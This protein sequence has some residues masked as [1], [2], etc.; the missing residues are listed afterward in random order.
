MTL[1]RFPESLII[2]LFPLLFFAANYYH[3]LHAYPIEDAFI[4]Y[5]YVKNFLSEGV[6]NFFPGGQPTEGATDF[7]WF[8]GLSAISAFGVSPWVSAMVL[9]ATGL[10]SIAVI[11]GK[12]TN[13]NRQHKS[14]M[15]SLFMAA[16]LFQTHLHAN[17]GGFNVFFYASFIVLIYYLLLEKR[18]LSWVPLLSLCLGLIRPDGV[19]IGVFYTL[20]GCR[21]A[22]EKGELQP[23]LISGAVAFIGGLS[24]FAW[25][26]NYF[27][28][29]LPLPLYVKS[30]NSETFLPGLKHLNKFI[31][32]YLHLYVLMAAFFFAANKRIKLGRYVFLAA[33]VLIHF[34]ILLFAEQSQNAGLRFQTPVVVISFFILYE[35]IQHFLSNQDTRPSKPYIYAALLFFILV[36]SIN[37]YRGIQHLPQARQYFYE[38]AYHMHKILPDKA[39]FALTEA[40][41]LSYW[42]VNNVV[43][44]DLVGLN[45][46]KFAKQSVEVKDI[47]EIDPDVVLFYNNDFVSIESM[48]FSLGYV[49]LHS[50]SQYKITNAE[51]STKVK[52]AST[53]AS[54]FLKEYFGDYDIFVT[55]SGFHIYAVKKQL[56]ISDTFEATLKTAT[57]GQDGSYH[58]FHTEMMKTLSAKNMTQ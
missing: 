10:L 1:K 57:A 55:G 56:N 46:E 34:L 7:L 15:L 19:I 44:Y 35:I 5:T 16:F 50:L 28:N 21:V 39:S 48:D 22:H 43:I 40:G 23:Y 3:H 33:P 2:L 13:P 12:R 11:I 27:G 32:K 8:L 18:F 36:S 20:I 51:V 58:L 31:V 41:A 14:L 30:F 54:A 45:N 25:R 6:I 38:F 29:L 37:V 49:K 42:N 26:F 47:R 52:A 9:N 24:Y 53:A 17:I 4:L